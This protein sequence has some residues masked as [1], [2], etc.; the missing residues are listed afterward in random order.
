MRKFHHL[1]AAAGLGCASLFISGAAM[2]QNY[3]DRPINWIIPSSAGSAFDVIARLITPKLSELLG[4]SVVIEN[5]AGAGGT[6]GA[7]K[8]ATQKADGY[9][10]LMINTNHSASAALYKSLGYDL[11]RDFDP[12]VNLVASHHVLVAKKDLEVNNLA[13]FV[14]LAKAKPGEL[15][16]AS[17]GVGS[18]TFL[19]GE[20]FK[21][22]A[23]IDLTHI[24]YAGGGPALASIVAGETD[25]YAAPYGTAKPFIDEGSVKALA[26]ASGERVSFDPELPSA[27]ETVPGYA[28][29]AW[30]GLAVPHGTPADVQDKIRQAV[31]ETL[32]DPKIKQQYLDLGFDVLDTGPEE[33]RAFVEKDVAAMTKVIQDSGI[34]PQ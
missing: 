31:S 25:F 7:T 20:L 16:I 19:C 1:I 18:A 13:D 28:F 6:V 22:V 14:A 15:N 4:Q 30:Y 27:S 5:L 32:A 21:S 12:L 24:P 2:A 9:T 34:Q 11:L 33:F 17:A 3:P 8:A 26:I 29:I 23:G 10:W